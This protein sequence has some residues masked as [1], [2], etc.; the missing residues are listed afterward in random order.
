MIPARINADAEQ[1]F[2]LR[3]ERNG[4][5]VVFVSREAKKQNPFMPHW[6]GPCGDKESLDA[7]VRWMAVRRDQWQAWGE[8]AEHIGGQAFAKHMDTL[9][10]S[11]PL[12]RV[13]AALIQRQD[14]PTKV[15][16]GEMTYGPAGTRLEILHVHR[17]QSE[18]ACEA[19]HDW[20]NTGKNHR[21]VGAIVEVAY[22]LGTDELGATLDEIAAEHL[23]TPKRAPRGRRRGGTNQRRRQLAA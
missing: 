21:Q 7:M 10:K 16:I 6:V 20:F 4:F 23:A 15:G 2:F 3:D 1:H 14:D 8:L 5:H 17:F 9:L 12:V 11:E 19:F 22:S 13:E 18:T